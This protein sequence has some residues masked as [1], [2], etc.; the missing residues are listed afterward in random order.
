MLLWTQGQPIC[1]D[2]QEE[3]AGGV[4]EDDA[5]AAAASAASYEQYV[6][7]RR[8]FAPAAGVEAPV[9]CF[10]VSFSVLDIWLV[11]LVL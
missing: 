3:E 7:C 9:A 2:S 10:G 6:R 8:T 1:V 4:G 11:L 5:A